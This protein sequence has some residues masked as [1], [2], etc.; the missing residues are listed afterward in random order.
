MPTRRWISPHLQPHLLAE[1]GVQRAEGLVQQEHLRPDD[2][3]TGERDP[4]L[5]APTELTGIAALES[6]Q[7]DQR[8][9][10]PH[11]RLGL[12]P[13]HPSH[14]EA[15]AD[16]LADGHVGEQGVVLEHHTGVAPVRGRRGDVDPLDAHPARVGP[17]EAGDDPEGRRL[18]APAGPQQ[19]DQLTGRD[20]E[21]DTI[22]RRDRAEP[23]HQLSEL[24]SRDHPQG[25]M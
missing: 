7:G 5:L 20:D 25:H 3:G 9:G 18:A 11:A 2:E 8:Q 24:E 23:L 14:A 4:L 13:V 10:L 6:A 12:P 19:R 1:L 15:E 16:I 17:L 21:I 22:H